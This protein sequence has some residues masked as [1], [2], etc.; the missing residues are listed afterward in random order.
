LSTSPIFNA[1]EP[2]Q[3][4]PCTSASTCKSFYDPQLHGLQM[5]CKYVLLSS[6]VTALKFSSMETN[7]L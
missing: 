3:T 5:F 4:L 7:G 1:S 6:K 2:V